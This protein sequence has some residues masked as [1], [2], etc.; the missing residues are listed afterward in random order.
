[1]AI[2]PSF[3]ESFSYAALEALAYG[4]PVVASNT[5]PRTLVAHG[6]N[7]FRADARDYAKLSGY[8]FKLLTN[9]DLWSEM[10]RNALRHVKRFSTDK[11]VDSILEVY[12]GVL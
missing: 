10:S 2:V 12:S 5:V 1:V 11:V 3:Y 9:D 7:G 6:I 4:T 8:V